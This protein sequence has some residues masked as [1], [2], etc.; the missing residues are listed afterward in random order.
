QAIRDLTAASTEA[1]IAQ[2]D[3]ATRAALVDASYGYRVGGLMCT[4]P[5]MVVLGG[6]L[7]A[8]L[9]A[10]GPPALKFLRRRFPESDG[11]T[12]RTSIAFLL[13]EFGPA[14]ARSVPALLAEVTDPADPVRRHTLRCSSAYALGKIDVASRKVVAG[15]ARVAGD[16]AESQPLRSYCLEA[17]MDLGP[18]A[19]AAIP[20][21]ERV[22]RH[23]ADEDLRNFAWSALKSVGAGS[24]DHPCGGTMAE[25]MRSLYRAVGQS[26]LDREQAE[27]GGPDGP[28]RA[29]E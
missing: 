17:L 25:H 11:V 14:A 4:I 27:S 21:L 8:G 6:V 9:L 20:V 7:D 19:R 13:A 18:A 12:G 24:R 29:D 16:G 28:G 23:D 26:E 22:F 3:E 10:L 2:S 5:P 15:L 1:M